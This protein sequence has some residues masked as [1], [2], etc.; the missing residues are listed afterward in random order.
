MQTADLEKYCEKA[1]EGGTTHAKVIHPS[2]VTTAEWVRFKCLF[3]C[4]YKHRYSCPP[5]TPKPEE[6]R[7]NLD[8]YHRAILFHVEAPYTKE[9]GKNMVAYLDN[10]VKLEGE[11]FKDGYYM[12]FVMLAGPCV[13]CKECGLIEGTP[14][15]L[16]HKTRPS[17]EACGID[18]YQT[19]RNNDFFITPLKE[20]SETQNLY[21]LMLVD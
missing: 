15:R 11:L 12:A 13:L 20:K 2:T 18:V 5:H 9:R 7:A 16:P 21:C 19:A 10:L 14:C 3:G 17:M 4:P 6:T 1:I 8:G